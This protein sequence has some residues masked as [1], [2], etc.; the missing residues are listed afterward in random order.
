[1][2][3]AC[4]RP[5]SVGYS[6]DCFPCRSLPSA[7]RADQCNMDLHSVPFCQKQ[8]VDTTCL[9]EMRGAGGSCQVCAIM[10][11]A[12]GMAGAGHHGSGRAGSPL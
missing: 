7:G 9:L 8:S 2:R 6:N 1:M 12:S 10:Y 4:G 11:C 5:S 3:L